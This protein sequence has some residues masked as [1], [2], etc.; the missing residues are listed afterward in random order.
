MPILIDWVYFVFPFCLYIRNSSLNAEGAVSAN[1]GAVLVTYLKC[2]ES[3]YS[4][5][6]E[7]RTGTSGSNFI[8]ITSKKICS[9]KRKLS[10]NYILE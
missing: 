9:E 7:G 1:L 3:R 6:D 10:L 8:L 4:S 2:S 5:D